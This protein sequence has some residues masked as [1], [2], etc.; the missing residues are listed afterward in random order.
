MVRADF[1]VKAQEVQFADVEESREFAQAIREQY[2]NKLL[3][4]N[5]SPSFNWWKFLDEQTIETF[6]QQIGELGY[7]FQFITLAGFHALNTATFE[8]AKG[9]KERGMG[10]FSEL[11][12][13]E[14]TMQ[15]EGFRAV[16]HQSFVGVGYFDAVQNTIAGGESSTAAL[17]DSTEADQFHPEQEQTTE[18]A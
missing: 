14:F 12:Q 11:Q 5:C 3:A 6:Q 17:K 1:V 18:A 10:A 4:Y 15:D 8:L 2:P 9:Y 7:K 13:R 16:K